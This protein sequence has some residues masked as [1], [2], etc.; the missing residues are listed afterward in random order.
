MSPGALE[1]AA[2][3]LEALLAEASR[4]GDAAVSEPLQSRAALERTARALEESARATGGA[5]ARRRSSPRA[6]ASSPSQ[7][8]GSWPGASPRASP[9]P[10][11]KGGASGAGGTGGA[12]GARGRALA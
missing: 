3:A 1:A 12:A 11:S 8:A 2:A 5:S 6:A 7:R 4:A 10:A 9:T